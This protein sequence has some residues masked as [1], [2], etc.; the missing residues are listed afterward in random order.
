MLRLA[1]AALLLVLSLPA[2]AQAVDDCGDMPGTPPRVIL[3]GQGLLESVIGGPDGRLYFTDTDKDALMR[4]DAPGADPVVVADGIDKPGGLL[5]G[6]D[7]ESIVVG[8]GDGFA[9]GAVGNLI[10]LAGLVRVDLATGEKTT[11]ATGTSMSNG[12]ARDPAGAV[13][14]SDDAGAGIDRVIGDRVERN[15][16]RVVSGNGLAVGSEGR[17]LYV[18]QTFQPAAVQRV[19]ITQPENVERY[20]APGPADTA[21]GLDGLT[22]DQDDRLFAAANA[23]GEV[24]RVGRDRRICAIARG[25]SMPSAVAFGS[26]GEFPATSLYAVTFGGDVVEIPAARASAPPP[27]PSARS[28]LRLR[29][30]PR[31]LRAGTRTRVTVTVRRGTRLEPRAR[32]RI[33]RKV[34]RTGSRGRARIFVRPRR[35]GFIVVRARAAGVPPVSQ[36]VRVLRP[37]ERPQA[38]TE[39]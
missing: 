33:G 3:G 5:V 29:V 32:V 24:W 8:Y 22:I 9:E 39:P 6:L 23:A 30:R 1:L 38:V 37:S 25:L 16:A 27:G 35:A 14:A 21:A 17:W 31:M 2:S 12:L 19:D 7:G 28:L 36:R 34:R 13:Y 11:I 20:A 4:L 10:G 18:N 26:G 15:W